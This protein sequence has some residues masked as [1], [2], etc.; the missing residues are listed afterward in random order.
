MES[1]S[2]VDLSDENI[3]GTLFS[4]NCFETFQVFSAWN[5]DGHVVWILWL[6]FSH[7]FCFVNLFYFQYEMLSKCIDSGYLVGAT[8]LAVF[9]QLFWNIADVFSMEWRCACSLGI[10]LWLLFSLFCFVNLV[11]FFTWNAIKVY[12]QWVPC[13]RNSSYNFPSIVLK[14]CRCFQHGM[15]TYM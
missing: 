14:L 11:S 3:L 9:H 5:E 8:P 7:F 4:T 13:G 12:R 6:F 10:I 2:S 15:K 1:P